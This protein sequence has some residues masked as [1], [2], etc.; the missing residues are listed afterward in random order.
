ML[1]DNAEKSEY[2]LWRFMVDTRFQGMGFGKRAIALLVE[3]VRTRPN[4]RQLLVSCIPGEGSPC[5][6]YERIGFEYTG[7]VK[8]GEKYMRLQL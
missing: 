2:F 1:Y 5:P 8:H 4:A 3:H 6:F 7:E